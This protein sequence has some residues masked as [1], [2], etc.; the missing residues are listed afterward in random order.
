MKLAI[1]QVHFERWIGI[2]RQ[3]VD[4]FFEGEIAE[5]AKW[6]SQKIA[7]TFQLKLEYSF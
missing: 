1:G 7:E 5:Q 4:D 3:T 6:R 2:L